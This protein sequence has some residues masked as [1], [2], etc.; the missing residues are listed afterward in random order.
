MWTKGSAQKPKTPS[1]EGRACATSGL[2]AWVTVENSHCKEEESRREEGRKETDT[3]TCILSNPGPRALGTFTHPILKP[4]MWCGSLHCRVR[5]PRLWVIAE[6]CSQAAA[7]SGAFAPGLSS[8]EAR[9]PSHSAHSFLDSLSTKPPVGL[10]PPVDHRC[11]HSTVP[12]LQ[13]PA[14]TSQLLR[15]EGNSTATTHRQR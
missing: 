8:L 13:A 12:A 14:K 11:S 2:L 7:G 15:L 3:A 10:Q 5:N 4:T 9:C 1:P 6:V